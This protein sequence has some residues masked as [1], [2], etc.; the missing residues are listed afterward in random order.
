MEKFYLKTKEQLFAHFKSSETGLKTE[1]LEKIREQYGKNILKEKEKKTALAIFLEQF[2]DFLVIILLVAASISFVSGNKESTIVIL[3]VITLNAILGTVQHIKAE[4]SLE[5]L[6]KMSSA[7]A[8]VMRDGKK[9]E[10]DSSELV[11]GDLVFIEAG[12]VVP[13]DARILE[14]HS[15]MVNESSL[16]GES[17]SVEKTTEI[18]ENDKLTIG[19]QKKYGF[20]WKFSNLWKRANFSYCYWAE[21]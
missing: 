6:K 21:N 3:A 10:I 4:E 9:S 2:K 7:K 18:F 20:L 5:S 1:D 12:D 15:L 11:P 17:E 13:S 16:T 19:D 8:K 14:S